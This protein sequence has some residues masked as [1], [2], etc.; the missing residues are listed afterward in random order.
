METLSCF[1][2]MFLFF[3]KTLLTLSFCFNGMFSLTYIK[4]ITSPHYINELHPRC[5]RVP[6]L[7]LS[8]YTYESNF[9]TMNGSENLVSVR[10]CSFETYFSPV[11]TNQLGEFQIKTMDWFLH[12]SNTELKW[13][14][15]Q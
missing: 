13:V 1:R 11:F 10:C 7:L 3:C 8:Q 15:S 12:N 9:E 5:Y 14:S 4:G 2:E 6:H